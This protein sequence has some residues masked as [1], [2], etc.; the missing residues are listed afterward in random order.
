MNMDA[1]NINKKLASWLEQYI[2]RIIHDDPV[3]FIPGMQ[4]WFNVHKSINMIDHINKRKDKNNMIL[5]YWKMQG[6]HLS[7]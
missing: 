7:W 5:S 4:V 1:K 2:K 6:E 3:G